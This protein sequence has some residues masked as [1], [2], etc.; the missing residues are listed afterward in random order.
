MGAPDRS[1]CFGGFVPA[2]AG[3]IDGRWGVT[4]RI[5][6]EAL[7]ARDPAITVDPDVLSVGTGGSRH[8]PAS[9]SA[10]ASS[11]ANTAMQ[12]RRTRPFG[13]SPRSSARSGNDVASAARPP[14]PR[15]GC[16]RPCDGG[17]DRG[18]ARTPVAMARMAAH[19]RM[20]P[21]TFARRSVKETRT[22]SGQGPIEAPTRHARPVLGTT[23]FPATGPGSTN[24]S[25]RGGWRQGLLDPCGSGG[26]RRLKDLAGPGAPR[27]G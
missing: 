18:P 10:C 14:R 4:Q 26:P 6:A 21:R 19:A 27:P 7:A 25:D 9:A 24:A 20:S 13:S 16:P 1:I 12:S 2:V 11:C 8:P 23:S 15:R 17:T 5:A 3:L 22:T